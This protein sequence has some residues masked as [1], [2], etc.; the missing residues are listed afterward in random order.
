MPPQFMYRPMF[1]VFIMLGFKVY[2]FGRISTSRL[3]TL[4]KFWTLLKSF[5]DTIASAAFPLEAQ[6][7]DP[8]HPYPG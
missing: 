5:A 4:A 1:L 8:M 3:L 6:W 7:P 2:L